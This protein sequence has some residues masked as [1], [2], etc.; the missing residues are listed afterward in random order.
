MKWI[1]PSHLRNA[2]TET[3][4][5]CPGSSRWNSRWFFFFKL[6]VMVSNCLLDKKSS[7]LTQGPQRWFFTHWGRKNQHADLLCL[8]AWFC[9]YHWLFF[10]ICYMVSLKYPEK[11]TTIH[12]EIWIFECPLPVWNVTCTLSLCPWVAVA[13]SAALFAR[14]DKGALC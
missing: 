3:R 10:F 13:T 12:K 9:I 14:G 5:K 7:Q 8:F 4:K 2:D 1:I 6:S 11:E